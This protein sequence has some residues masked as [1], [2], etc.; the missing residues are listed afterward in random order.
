M[1]G[2]GDVGRGF[3]DYNQAEEIIESI[4]SIMSFSQ[5]ISQFII[6]HGFARSTQR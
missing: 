4:R 2:K 3:D 1:R 5:T 6:N